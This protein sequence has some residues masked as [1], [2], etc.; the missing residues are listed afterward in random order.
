MWRNYLLTAWRALRRNPLYTAI[1]VGGLALGL[2]CCFLLVLFVENEWTYD[3][4]HPEADRIFRVNRTTETAGR[5]TEIQGLTPVPLAGILHQ[6]DPAVEHA[7]RVVPV[8]ETSVHVSA[9][10]TFAVRALYADSSFA[11]V[12][13][14]PDRAGSTHDAL[15]RPNGAVLTTDAARRLFGTSAA[16]GRTLTVPYENADDAEVTVGAVVTPPPTNSSLEFD[17]LLPF[18]LYPRTR[19]N[20]RIWSFLSESWD[21][22]IVSTFVRLDD[23]AHAPAAESR[24]Q[25]L[26]TERLAGEEETSNVRTTSASLQPLPAIHLA[27][28]V[29]SPF[30]TRSPTHIYV[31]T[32]LAGLILLIACVNFTTLSLG[33]SMQRIREVGVRKSFGARVGQIRAQFAGEALLVC[34]FAAVLGFALAR[35]ALPTFNALAQESLTFSLLESPWRLGVSALLVT[36]TGIAAG[37]YPSILLARL[38]PST[39]LRG[40]S[41]IRLGQT[42]TKGLMVVQFALSI[43]FLSG[44]LVIDRQLDYALEKPLGFDTHRLITFPASNVSP[45]Q[46]EEGKAMAFQTGSAYTTFK[47]QARQHPEIAGVTALLSPLGTRSSGIDAAL[48]RPDGSSLPV[49]VNG[50]DSSFVPVLGINVVAG[51]GMPRTGEPD[52]VVVNR[53]LVDAMGWSTPVGHTLSAARSGISHVLD[54][55]RVVGVVENFHYQTLHEPIEPLVLMSDKSVVGSQMHVAVRLSDGPTASA[56]ESVRSVWSEVAPGAPF[57]Y[58]FLDERLAAQY[59]EERRWRQITTWGAALALA[60]AAAGLFGLATLSARRR[61]KEIGIRKALGA[62]VPRILS[63]ISKD[64]LG[65]VAL[66]FVV[67]VPASYWAMSRWLQ[68]FAYRIDQPALWLGMAGLLTLLVAAVAVGVQAVRAAQTNPADVIRRE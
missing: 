7:T 43:A 54:G 6:Q 50:V 10:H 19:S 25:A 17:V 22:G 52:R 67:A 14:F 51:R 59:E 4:F 2:A 37:A 42:A 62:S 15:S 18:D 34:V 60:I 23:A 64:F 12:F 13:A 47:Q 66:A 53:A 55:A 21:S 39:V 1:T 36:A 29:N 49:H 46:P 28:E 58:Q 45:D 31:L 8:S 26:F 16:V 57:D 35:L 30:P 41:S 44:A 24:L 33:Q 65:L 5:G 63:L 40:Q 9:E 32:A 38:T 68:Q 3:T 20:A 27:S 11:N 61:R 48:S 56:L